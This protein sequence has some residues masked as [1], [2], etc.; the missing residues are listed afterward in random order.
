[1]KVELSKEQ[2]DMILNWQGC[3]ENEF[4]EMCEEEKELTD[5]LYSLI[6]E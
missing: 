6:D 4:G 1:M 5:Y 2:I 3:T